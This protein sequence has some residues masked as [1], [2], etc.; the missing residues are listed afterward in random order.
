VEPVQGLLETSPVAMPESS[1]VASAR[2]TVRMDIIIKLIIRPFMRTPRIL[3]KEKK[4]K[5]Q[6]FSA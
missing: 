3:E 5:L 4:K 1:T 2:A 6:A